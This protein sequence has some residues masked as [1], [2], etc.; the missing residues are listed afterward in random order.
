MIFSVFQKNRVFGYSWP[1]L[2]WYRCYYPHRSRDALSPVCGI[3]CYLFRTRWDNFPCVSARGRW[4]K[5][6]LGKV[7][8]CDPANGWILDTRGPER[9]SQYSDT[10]KKYA[11]NFAKKRLN[12]FFWHIWRVRIH[13]RRYFTTCL[14]M[15]LA[16]IRCLNLITHQNWH[17]IPTMWDRPLLLACWTWGF[18]SQTGMCGWTGTN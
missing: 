18:C 6:A 1:T 16:S 8:W 12:N 5:W 15:A 17:R 13:L 10:L 14:E 9:T 4:Y 11:Y 7:W 3:F 2:L